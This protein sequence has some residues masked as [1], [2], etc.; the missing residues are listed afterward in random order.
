[1]RGFEQL[2]ATALPPWRSFFV[3][4]SFTSSAEKELPLK[5]VRQQERQQC[6][7]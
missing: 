4:K 5:Q 6:Q 2:C 1:M 7:Q 3:A